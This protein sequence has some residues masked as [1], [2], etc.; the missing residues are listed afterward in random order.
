MLNFKLYE[1]HGQSHFLYALFILFPLWHLIV[2]MHIRKEQILKLKTLL[3]TH[4]L[5]IERIS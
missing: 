4:D 5:E 2:G 1:S 3:K